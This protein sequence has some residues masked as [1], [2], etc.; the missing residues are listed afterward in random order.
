MWRS[1]KNCVATWA[2]PSAQGRHPF[3]VVAGLRAPPIYSFNIFIAAG[4][5]L[6]L[7]ASNTV[8][9]FQ[10]WLSFMLE[11]VSVVL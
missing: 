2:A 9:D 5:D 4:G 8:T 7:L 10:L 6:I 3:T 1:A 11:P